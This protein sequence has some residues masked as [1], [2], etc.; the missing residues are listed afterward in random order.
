M[1]I[2][3][4]WLL[5]I[6]FSW[7][8]LSGDDI[9]FAPCSSIEGI[10]QQFPKRYKIRLLLQ[11]A[12]LVF[13]STSRRASRLRMKVKVRRRIMRK[14]KTESWMLAWTCWAGNF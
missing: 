14:D 6:S 1:Y 2:L 13:T 5:M 11:Y 4:C 12:K 10:N 7:R 9:G 3:G 8:R